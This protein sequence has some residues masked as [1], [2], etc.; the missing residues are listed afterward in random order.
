[1]T[2]K[3]NHEHCQKWDRNIRSLSEEAEAGTLTTKHVRH[4]APLQVMRCQT[5]KD[6]RQ[7]YPLETPPPQMERTCLPESH[8]WDTARCLRVP[9]AHHRSSASP[10]GILHRLTT[11][12]EPPLSSHDAH[13]LP[14]SRAGRLIL[15]KTT[16]T[17]FYPS[18]IIAMKESTC[19]LKDHNLQLIQH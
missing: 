9:R 8:I 3:A 13:P 10:S 1:M 14:G 18:K 16:Q 7:W 19:T 17:R 6:P 2:H 12:S 15:Q 11:R 4:T 5:D